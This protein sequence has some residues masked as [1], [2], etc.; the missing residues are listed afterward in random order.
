M[1]FRVEAAVM[2]GR[3]I[4]TCTS[5]TFS[6][7]VLKGI[8]TTLDVGPVLNDT[9]KRHHYRKKREEHIEQPQS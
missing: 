9:L 7:N 6:R 4:P 5:Q 3:T 8:K 2:Q 1:L